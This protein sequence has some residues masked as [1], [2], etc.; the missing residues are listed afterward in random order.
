MQQ[1]SLQNYL[2]VLRRQAWLIVL[3]PVLAAALA[4]FVSSKQTPVYRAT[5]NMFIH[6][7]GGGFPP[8]FGSQ[9]LSQTMASVLTSDVVA[10]Q[11]IRELNL[12][13]TPE[14]LNKKL[15]VTFKPDDAVLHVTYDS[16]DKQRAVAV[17]SSISDAYLR[18]LKTLKLGGSAPTAPGIPAA[19]PPKISAS[20]FDPARAEKD[21]V[22]P[23]PAKNMGFA[24]ALGLV[25]GLILAV[26]RERLDDRVRRRRDAEEWFGAPV[27]GALPK[28]ATGRPPPAISGERRR[29]HEELMEALYTFRANVEFSQDGVAGPRVLITSASEGEGKTTVAAH[30]GVALALAGKDVI[31]VEVDFRRPELHRYLGLPEGTPGIANVLNGELDLHGA[32][33]PV[34]LLLRPGT[35]G[36]GPS[37]QEAG[38][39]LGGE[40]ILKPGA[41]GSLRVLTMGKAPADP[42]LLASDGLRDLVQELVEG[43]KPDYVIFDA[44]PL[45]IADAYPLVHQADNVLVVAKQGWTKRDA[46]VGVRE[47]LD[48]LGAEK[49]AVVISDS[50]A[51]VGGYGYG[52]GAG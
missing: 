49:V 40:G 37:Q 30:M 51:P 32:L 17:L 6:Q 12:D 45:L 3:V 25:L 33:Q 42:N 29:G 35:N 1:T 4:W 50:T 19:P 15:K 10:N 46:A 24:L 20:V 44:P 41:H 5:M 34:K 52:H 13:T 2:Q 11:A 38:V 7:S 21:K 23:K 48:G 43:E 31:C 9:A 8:D 47:T 22:S 27:V 28:S 36:S 18:V 39:Q 14:K 16:T 26:A